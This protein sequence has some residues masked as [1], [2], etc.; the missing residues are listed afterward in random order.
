MLLC[1]MLALD[2]RM[3]CS[4]AFRKTTNNACWERSISSIR[5]PGPRMC[6]WS[7]MRSSIRISRKVPHSCTRQGNFVSSRYHSNA[8]KVRRRRAL[9]GDACTR[10]QKGC[11][12]TIPHKDPILP[13]ETTKVSAAARTLSFPEYLPDIT[14]SAKALRDE[15]AVSEADTAELAREATGQPARHRELKIKKT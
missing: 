5:S 1:A 15:I 2:L 3:F 8:P 7:T 6:W 13:W 14:F 11:F 4:A 10:R 12:K 9:L